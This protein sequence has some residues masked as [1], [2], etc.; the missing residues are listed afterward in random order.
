MRSLGGCL[1]GLSL[2]P[3]TAE[4][5]VFTSGSDVGVR[6]VSFFQPLDGGRDRVETS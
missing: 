2:S 5:Q 1:D 6:Q 4:G 3:D